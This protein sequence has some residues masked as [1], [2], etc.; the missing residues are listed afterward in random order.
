MIKGTNRFF[1]KI[2]TALII[3]IQA[4]KQSHVFKSKFER[5]VSY[6]VI[7]VY[8]LNQFLK[9]ILHI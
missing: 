4:K 6:L 5:V 8:A 9:K 2:S 3:L 1:S 7:K